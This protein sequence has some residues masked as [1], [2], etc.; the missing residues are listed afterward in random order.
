MDIA[1]LYELQ[2]IDANMEKVR[3]RVAQIR[4]NLGE[5][6]ELRAARTAVETTRA[7][8]ERLHAHQLDAELSGQQL[9][10]RIKAS[11]RRLMS[12]EVHN[13]KELEALQASI[14]SMK[15]QR[16]QVEDDAMA[17][18]QQREEA[19]QQ[20]VEQRVTL[21]QVEAAWQSTQAALQQEEA[22]Y[23]RMYAQLKQQRQSVTERLG[24][25]A[26]ALYAQLAERKAGVAVAAVQNGAC[27]AC[28]VSLPTGIVA[29]ARVIEGNPV[30]C[31]S[32]GRILF[33]G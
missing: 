17:T 4:R 25:D 13:A 32:C 10:D 9:G 1:R 14:A 23:K 7:T 30:F 26:L 2:K 29:N 5:S 19:E 21:A 22:K 27:S 6:D 33:A 31:P 24:A 12:G 16:S 28:N 11:E 8:V 20:L 15:R 3:R 18:F